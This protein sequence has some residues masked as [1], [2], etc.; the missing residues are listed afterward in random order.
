[1]DL[2]IRPRQ[3]TGLSV[4]VLLAMTLICAC[5]PALQQASG[6]VIDIDSPALGRVDSFQLLTSDGERLT[7]D[8]TQMTFRAEFPAAHLAEHR[9]LGS[10][11]VVTYKEDGGDLVVTQLDDAP[12]GPGH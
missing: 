3:A 1:M 8:T 6:V 7:F 12:E 2:P 5:T 9:V 11:I 10:R 4:L